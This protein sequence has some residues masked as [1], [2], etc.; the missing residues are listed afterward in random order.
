[1]QPFSHQQHNLNYQPICPSIIMSLLQTL[2]SLKFNPFST[3]ILILICYTLVLS[4]TFIGSNQTSTLEAQVRG[5]QD[6]LGD[7]RSEVR[8]LRQKIGVNGDVNVD[9]DESGEPKA[10]IDSIKGRELLNVLE[11]TS[12][13][14]TPRKK[15]E[16]CACCEKA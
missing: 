2:K 7:L 15:N 1:V 14:L 3:L 4:I 12:V 6:E 8:S 13:S 9:N 5:M 16:V 10:P 11:S